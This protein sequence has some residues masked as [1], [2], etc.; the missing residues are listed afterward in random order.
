MQQNQ[1]ETKNNHIYSIALN[2]RTVRFAHSETKRHVTQTKGFDFLHISSF[3]T[4]TKPRSKG[5]K[6]EKSKDQ[7]RNEQKEIE[8]L[9]RKYAW[10]KLNLNGNQSLQIIK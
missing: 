9:E 4:A 1:K 3:F 6:R 10:R 5:R 2:T 8:P 7:M